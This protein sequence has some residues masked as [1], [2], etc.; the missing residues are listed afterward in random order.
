MVGLSGQ[1][2]LPSKSADAWV[3]FEQQFD[4]AY[5]K[6]RQRQLY[7][8]QAFAVIA[9]GDAVFVDNQRVPPT[10]GMVSP[11]SHG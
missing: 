10:S 1:Q 4:L 2:L 3:T 5:E 9:Q 11:I 7:M 8:G 6:A